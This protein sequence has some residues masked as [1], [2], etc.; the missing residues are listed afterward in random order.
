MHAVL[1]DVLDGLR[2]KR[3]VALVFYLLL[4]HSIDFNLDGPRIDSSIYELDVSIIGVFVYDPERRRPKKK[5]KIWLVRSH[6]PPQ[7]K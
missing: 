1:G 7:E 5:V 6:R 4:F 3:L 2:S